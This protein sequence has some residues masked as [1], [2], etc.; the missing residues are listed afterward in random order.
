MW[1]YRHSDYDSLRLMSTVT[2]RFLPAVAFLPAV[3]QQATNL[4]TLTRTAIRESDPKRTPRIT[5]SPVV[6]SVRWLL[7]H[8]TILHSQA[9]MQVSSTA[10]TDA[11]HGAC[12]RLERARPSPRSWRS[13]RRH[14][15]ERQLSYCCRGHSAGTEFK[16]PMRRRIVL[17]SSSGLMSRIKLENLL[18]DDSTKSLRHQHSRINH[19]LTCW[20]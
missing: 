17:P 7:A 13:R 10:N 3:R 2:S 5:D 16:T 11:R 15:A 19:M 18:G 12:A 6:R 8:P 20:R 9:E 1:T 4:G 14:A